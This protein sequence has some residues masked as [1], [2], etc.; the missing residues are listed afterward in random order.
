MHGQL[1]KFI[2][3][4]WPNKK[5][6]VRITNLLVLTINKYIYIYIFGGYN[7][8]LNSPIIVFFFFFEQMLILKVDL[9]KKKIQLQAYS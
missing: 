7:C 4:C 2:V 1:T 9:R 6:Q 8:K 3:D 5:I